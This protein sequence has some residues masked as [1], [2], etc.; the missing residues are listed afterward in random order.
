MWNATWWGVL[1]FSGWSP[2]HAVDIDLYLVQSLKCWC[3]RW[4]IV[5]ILD[6]QWL[7]QVATELDGFLYTTNIVN[8]LSRMGQPATYKVQRLASVYV[9]KMFQES[10]SA[11]DQ[12]ESSFTKYNLALSSMQDYMLLK[13]LTWQCLVKALLAQNDSTSFSNLLHS[14][15]HWW[16]CY[17]PYH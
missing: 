15:F 9:S 5:D 8:N 13:D 7:N 4:K 2:V 1:H 6:I 11:I 10:H 3:Q 16:S 12:Y 17:L 14:G